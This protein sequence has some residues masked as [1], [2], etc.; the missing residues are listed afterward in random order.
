MFESQTG[1]PHNLAISAAGADPV[2]RSE[3]F[4]GPGSETIAVPA[5]TAGTYAFKCDVHPDMTGTLTVK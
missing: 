5:L 3:V 1:D 2:V 4:S